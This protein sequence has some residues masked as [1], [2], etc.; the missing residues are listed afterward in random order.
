MWSRMT[1]SLRQVIL[2][3][4]VPFTLGTVGAGAGWFAAGDTLG[5]WFAGIAIVAILVPPLA[6]RHDTPF[7]ALLAAGSVIDGVGVV[8]LASVFFTATTS[9][10]WLAAY[11]L[12]A[13]FGLA[14]LGLVLALRHGTGATVAAGITVLLAIAWLTWPVWLS[15]WLAGSRGA[16]VAAWLVPAHPL[17]ALNRIFVELG[18]WT[19]QP[20]MYRLTSL[21][22]DVPMSL[23]ASVW[24]SVVT[25]AAIALATA[26]PVLMLPPP[27]GTGTGPAPGPEASAA[28]R[29]SASSRAS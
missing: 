20:L 2:A 4:A 8:W 27:R 21:G 10:Q 19:Q 15:P 25:H 16:L 5:F 17:F 24:P 6:A 28:R 11:V 29:D 18:M 14:L 13:A 12:L 23:P 22:Q 3:A 9:L 26:G 1:P 7:D